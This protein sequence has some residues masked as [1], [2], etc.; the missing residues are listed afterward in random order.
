M[1]CC[2]AEASDTSTRVQVPPS[3]A[4]WVEPTSR[5]AHAE[6]EYEAMAGPVCA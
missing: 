6:D 3:E 5:S 2:A 4:G 1:A